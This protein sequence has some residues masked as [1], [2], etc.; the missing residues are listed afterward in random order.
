MKV[1]VTYENGEVF[2]HFGHSE[3]FKLYEVEGGEVKSSE[4]VP[5]NGSGHGALAGFLRERGVE[6]L[7]CGGIGAGALVSNCMEEFQVLRIVRFRR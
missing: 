4:V 6:V 1:A 3:A 7:I 2:Q 5:T